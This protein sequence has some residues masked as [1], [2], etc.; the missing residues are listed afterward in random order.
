LRTFEHADGLIHPPYHG[1][2]DDT[3]CLLDGRTSGRRLFKVS[4]GS[5]QPAI[6]LAYMTRLAASS[7]SNV[8]QR[9]SSPDR[10]RSLTA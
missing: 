6:S 3:L 9:R 7:D 1:L 10:S 4:M 5:A 8:A 2:R